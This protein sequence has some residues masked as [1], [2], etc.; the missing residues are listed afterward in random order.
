MKKILVLTF[1]W[2]PFCLINAQAQFTQAVVSIGGRVNC[3]I[4]RKPLSVNIEIFDQNGQRINKIKSNAS[5]GSY[6]ITGL[7]SGNSY[8]IRFSDFDY[9]KY[10]YTM[11]IPPTD[12]YLEYSKDFLIIPKKAQTQVQIPVKLFETRK[13][14]LKVGADQFLIDY[15]NLL[16]SNPTVKIRIVSY[17]DDNSNSP[18]NLSLTQQRSSSIKDFFI[19]NGIDGGRLQTE[20]SQAIDPNNPPPSGK[21]S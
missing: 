17:P 13:S 19:S 16:K 7:K 5:D 15:I 12:K 8:E 9:M 18:E 20:G 1:L 14:T 4:D 6:F 21:A 11:Q 3:V 2:L 10:S